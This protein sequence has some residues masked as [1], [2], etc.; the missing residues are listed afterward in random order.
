M[1]FINTG[2][3]NESSNNRMHYST[4]R[5]VCDIYSLISEIDK[6]YASQ[7]E[8]DSSYEL[9]YNDLE[10]IKKKLIS[11]NYT[12]SPLKLVLN[13]SSPTEDGFVPFIDIEAS[14]DD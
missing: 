7:K 12:F 8:I 6:A 10:V 9:T 5:L 13:N 1:K 3:Y 2:I 4:N 11:G 14:L